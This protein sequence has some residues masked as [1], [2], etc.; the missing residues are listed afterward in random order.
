M[1]PF[2]PATSCGDSPFGIPFLLIPPVLSQALAGFVC[3]LGGGLDA[4][5]V[6]SVTCHRTH[7]VSRPK[8]CFVEVRSSLV[9]M[10]ISCC[11]LVLPLSSRLAFVYFVYVLLIPRFLHGALV[12][13]SHRTL[14]T[15]WLRYVWLR[16]GLAHGH[17]VAFELGSPHS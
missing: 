7:P 13:P 16:Q 17:S 4:H 9:S 10:V 8:C 15:A 11:L 12:S 2:K 6:D 14:T 3:L 1:F 5:Y